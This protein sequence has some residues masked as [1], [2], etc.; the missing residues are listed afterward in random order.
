M[1]YYAVNFVDGHMQVVGAD[2]LPPQITHPMFLS[3]ETA[4]GIQEIH[5]APEHRWWYVTYL[6]A[7]PDS[8]KLIPYGKIHIN[9]DT[10]TFIK[11]T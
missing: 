4:P 1:K 3:R 8:G 5:V 11:E 7:D 2:N 10:V 9:L 6:H